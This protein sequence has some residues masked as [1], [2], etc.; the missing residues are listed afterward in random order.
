MFVKEA[1]GRVSL[2]VDAGRDGVLVAVVL[3]GW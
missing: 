1:G 2:V 3:A